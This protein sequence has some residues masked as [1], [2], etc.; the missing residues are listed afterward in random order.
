M[1]RAVSLP[2][3]YQ[4]R[5]HSVGGSIQE[6]GGDEQ[7][8]LPVLPLNR[9]HQAEGVCNSSEVYQGVVAAWARKQTS[10]GGITSHLA[11]LSYHDH[12]ENKEF[13]TLHFFQIGAGEPGN[14]ENGVWGYGRH[15]CDRWASLNF[16]PPGL[17]SNFIVHSFPLNVT[18]S[19]ID[20]IFL[21]LLLIYN[22]LNPHPSSLG[23]AAA[24]VVGG[25][26]GLCMALKK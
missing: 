9:E 12:I 13:F 5:H 22:I 11:N 8:R 19:I 26:V 25:I 14:Q 20:F 2:S 10:S 18:L 1:P 7:A 3:G 4:E 21:T 23:G 17:D 24:L 15:G 16:I 6:P